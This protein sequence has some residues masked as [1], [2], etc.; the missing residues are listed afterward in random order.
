MIKSRLRS[1]RVPVSVAVYTKAL[2]PTYAETVVTGMS[3]LSATHEQRDAIETAADTGAVIVIT[4]VFWFEPEVGSTT[5]PAIT[6]AHL[7][8]VGSTRYEV[9]QVADQ[10]GNGNRLRVTTRRLR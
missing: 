7:L 10:G 6:E 3:S 2:S 8:K 1:R 5:L 4:D 9:I